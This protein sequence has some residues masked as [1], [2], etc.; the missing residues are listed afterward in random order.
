MYALAYAPRIPVLALPR[1]WNEGCVMCG[2][3]GDRFRQGELSADDVALICLFPSPTEHQGPYAALELRSFREYSLQLG[4]HCVACS[5]NCYL[6]WQPRSSGY[7]MTYRKTFS[8][9]GQSC[10]SQSE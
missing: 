5:R 3:R 10:S 6:E 9:W 2:V 4:R 8:E 7:R 1:R